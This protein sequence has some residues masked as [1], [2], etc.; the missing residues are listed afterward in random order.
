MQEVT[1][2]S[3]RIRINPGIDCGEL[4]DWVVDWAQLFV[5]GLAECE[6]HGPVQTGTT[7]PPLT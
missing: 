3:A 5:V 4:L 1:D 2:T 7:V 6:D